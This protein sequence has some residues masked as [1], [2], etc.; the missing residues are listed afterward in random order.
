MWVLNNW[1]S[2]YPKSCCLSVGYV[3]LSGLPCRATVG[4][5]V[6]SQAPQTLDMPGWAD[7]QGGPN[8]LEEMERGERKVVGGGDRERGL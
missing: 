3:L 6:V 4:E 2:N 8:L 1:S 5:V 7:T